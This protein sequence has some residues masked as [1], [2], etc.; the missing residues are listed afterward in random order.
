[1]L[2][3]IRKRAADLMADTLASLIC[4]GLFA[5]LMLARREPRAAAT[6]SIEG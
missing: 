5:Y 6:Q 1:M 4:I 2:Q 3:A